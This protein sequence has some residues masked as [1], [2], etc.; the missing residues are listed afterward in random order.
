MFVVYVGV[1]LQTKNRVMSY[2]IQ[3]YWMHEIYWWV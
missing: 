3:M 2:S 1:N